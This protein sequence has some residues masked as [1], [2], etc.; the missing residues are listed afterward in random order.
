MTLVAHAHV[1]PGRA[2][3]DLLVL[4]VPEGDGHRRF[5]CAD[6]YCIDPKCHC[7]VLHFRLP[8]VTHLYGEGGVPDP[9]LLLGVLDGGWDPM[10]PRLRVDIEDS[11]G[12]A[13]ILAEPEEPPWT[14]PDLRRP[15]AQV[16]T[17]ER[18]DVFAEHRRAVVA[19]G[20]DNWW[21]Y[22]DWSAVDLTLCVPWQEV[23]PGTPHLDVQHDGRAYLLDD[24]YCA[25]PDCPCMEALLTVFPSTEGGH[26]RGLGT[27]AVPL[28]AE[29]TRLVKVKDGDGAL[30]AAV[31]ADF[32]ASRPAAFDLLIGRKR[33]MMEFGRHVR[34]R[35]NRDLPLAPWDRRRA[36]P[37]RMVLQN[38]PCPCG[39]GR[40]YKNCCGRQ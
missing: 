23:F 38:E 40:K 9:G 11:G 36:V 20:R 7:E 13:T 27:V 8:E 34:D 24:Q 19:W 16:L 5:L 26:V 21:R 39:S 33:R 6:G 10:R 18:L 37:R 4:S 35:W 2:R 14:G 17:R 32:L 30:V 28:G 3:E 31:T 25:Q 12:S 15:L 29:R 1:D 22:Q